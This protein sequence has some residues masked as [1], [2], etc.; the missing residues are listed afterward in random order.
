MNGK[1]FNAQNQ[2][3]SGQLQWRMEISFCCV[4]TQPR[5]QT[6]TCLTTNVRKC[7]RLSHYK[8]HWLNV[9]SVWWK[10]MLSSSI[11]FHQPTGSWDIA[12][13]GVQRL[14]A[15][16]L[17]NSPLTR[18]DKHDARNKNINSFTLSS[19]LRRAWFT[20]CKAQSNHLFPY[21][22]LPQGVFGVSDFLPQVFP[23]FFTHSS[24]HLPPFNQ[25]PL[26]SPLK[27]VFGN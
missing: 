16:C 17:E 18:K 26:R 7:E 4:A 9:V 19:I 13:K 6:V 25:H 2:W 5:A 20:A 24:L 10:I 12:Q 21:F 27:I 14:D 8:G 11:I 1:A 3:S 22:F 15:D 23:R